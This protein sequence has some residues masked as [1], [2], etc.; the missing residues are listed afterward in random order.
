[1]AARNS[2]GS[3]NRI[4]PASVDEDGIQRLVH[5][6]YHMVQKDPVIGPVFLR[7]IAPERW[8]DHLATMCAFWSSVLLRTDHYEGRPLAPHLTMPDLSDAHFECWLGL[9][10]TTAK[11]VFDEDGALM[12]IAF[13]ERIAHSF[14]MAIAFHR[15][16]DTSAIRPLP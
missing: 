11:E 10:R 12:V 13:A 9:F 3:L 8:P 1:M 14:R 7:Q 4:P 5:R 16:E 2:R 15:G 6:F